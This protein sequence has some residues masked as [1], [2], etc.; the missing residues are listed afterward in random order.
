MHSFNYLIIQHRLILA[1]EYSGDG[2]KAADKKYQ[3]SGVAFVPFKVGKPLG[4]GEI[5][6]NNFVGEDLKNPT[7]PIA[8]RPIDL[9]QGPD[10]ALYV[11]DDMKGAIFRIAYA[12][13][14]K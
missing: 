4:D 7:A 9:A 6:A 3:E 8:H 12:N 11:S 5:F 13:E 10:G 1:P 2:K 14:K